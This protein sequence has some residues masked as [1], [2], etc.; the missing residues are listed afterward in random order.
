MIPPASITADDALADFA[1]ESD[2]LL[3]DMLG[4]PGPLSAGAGGGGM[5]GGGGGCTPLFLLLL[6]IDWLLPPLAGG[7]GETTFAAP[8]P[9]ASVI[10]ASSISIG[11]GSDIDGCM[12]VCS[13]PD[14]GASIVEVEVGPGASCGAARCCF[15]FCF[16]LGVEPEPLDFFFDRL[17]I[18]HNAPNG[19]ACL[20]SIGNQLL[21]QVK[22]IDQCQRHLA[23]GHA[24]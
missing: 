6:G 17:P 24:C 16:L 21:C 5:A 19:L 3:P 10:T 23:Q 11:S 13:D 4:I 15:F 9:V 2:I 1:F 7:D 12:F 18:S 22:S 14:G 20:L 8:A